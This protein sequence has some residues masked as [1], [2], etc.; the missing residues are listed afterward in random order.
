MPARPKHTSIQTSYEKLYSHP[1]IILNTKSVILNKC[2]IKFNM[3]Y[4]KTYNKDIGTLFY[5]KHSV[6]AV[7]AFGLVSDI[8]VSILSK[9]TLFSRFFVFFL[10]LATISSFVFVFLGARIINKN[11]NVPIFYLSIAVFESISMLSN[12][13]GYLYDDFTTRFIGLVV[14]ILLITAGVGAYSLVKDLG[15]WSLSFSI[16]SILTGVILTLGAVFKM[17][18]TSI[19]I[20]SMSDIHNLT[21]SATILMFIGA[22]TLPAMVL[23]EYKLFSVAEAIV[24]TKLSNDKQNL[25]RDITTK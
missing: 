20:N 23:S 10:D 7:F 15:K 12:L 21:S 6:W 19:A 24:T 25:S 9:D 13:F 1:I 16:F 8:C 17:H 5:A 22:I 3:K 18:L 14:G 11:Y 2:Y 4:S